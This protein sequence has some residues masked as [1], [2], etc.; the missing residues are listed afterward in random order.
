MKN[1]LKNISINFLTNLMF[2]ILIIFCIQN[3]NSKRTFDFLSLKTIPLPVSFI[4]GTSFVVGS[5][6]G[7]L[8]ANYF[9]KNKN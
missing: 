8:I 6:N 7:G 9:N 2:F 4:V 3:S 1:A 5:L